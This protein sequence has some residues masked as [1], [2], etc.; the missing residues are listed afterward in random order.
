MSGQDH[1]SHMM[2]DRAIRM[3]EQMGYV[4]QDR[5]EP[6]EINREEEES[7]RSVVLKRTIWGLYQ[8]DT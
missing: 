4:S 2:L 3:A 8:L 1:P 7:D 5:D 6:L